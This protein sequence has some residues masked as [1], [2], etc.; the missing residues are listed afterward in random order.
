MDKREVK[1]NYWGL[2]IPGAILLTLIVVALVKRGASGV[3]GGFANTG[4]LLLSV[5]PNLALGFTLAGFLT[6]LIPQEL[7][8]KWIGEGSGAKGIFIGSLAGALTPGG[9]FTHFPI[10]A[11]LLSKG[12]GIGPLCAYIAAWALLGVH[13]LIIWEGPL[14]GWKFV[15][16]RVAA[17]LVV[18]PLTG[19]L[20]QVLAAAFKFAPRA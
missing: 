6:L 13:R 11:S 2:L 12:A 16:I 10:L 19:W 20:A 14:M 3:G 1:M 7:I 15:A 17:C 4:K 5:A 8:A 9:P 18:P